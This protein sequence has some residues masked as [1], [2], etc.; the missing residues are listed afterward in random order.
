[1]S[2]IIII[3]LAVIFLILCVLIILYMCGFFKNRP[4]DLSPF[5][6]FEY[7]IDPNLKKLAK[8]DYN[9]IVDTIFTVL[10]AQTRSLNEAQL[11]VPS[12]RG[13]PPVIDEINKELKPLI[14]HISEKYTPEIKGQLIK[15]FLCKHLVAI[16]DNYYTGPHIYIE[17]PDI[18]SLHIKAFPF[19]YDAKRIP[20]TKPGRGSRIAPFKYFAHNIPIEIRDDVENLYDHLLRKYMR[21]LNGL[22]SKLREVNMRTLQKI[23]WNEFIIKNS[24]DMQD[25]LFKIQRI[26]GLNS[27]SILQS[28]LMTNVLPLLN[29][30]YKGPSINFTIPASIP[31]NPHL[32]SV[33]FP[34]AD[35]NLVFTVKPGCLEGEAIKKVNTGSFGYIKQCVRIR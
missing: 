3:S 18:P 16:L 8:K 19:N 31:A 9:K 25:D 28:I 20:G 10:N 14:D 30:Y 6:D 4:S 33:N 35:N 22:V 34:N 12:K 17:V 11:F 24:L 29:K 27:A 1:M 5:K 7:A 32:L 2:S 23:N 26:I 15:Y 13:V 21:L